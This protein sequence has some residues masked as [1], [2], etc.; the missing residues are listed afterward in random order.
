MYSV[1][2]NTAVKSTVHVHVLSNTL[3]DFYRMLLV[4]H[5]NKIALQ[6]DA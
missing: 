1:Y 3:I 4:T 6:E 2:E 5:A